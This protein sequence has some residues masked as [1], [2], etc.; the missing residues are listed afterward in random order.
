MSN[1]KAIYVTR[2]ALISAIYF[3]VIGIYI[4]GSCLLNDGLT[5]QVLL[6][7]LLFFIPILYHN[8][9]GILF[10]GAV[11][12]L[13]LGLFTFWGMIVFASSTKAMGWADYIGAGSIMLLFLGSLSFVWQGIRLGTTHYTQQTTT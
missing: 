11:Y 10:I 4:V 13:F 6:F 12:S 5:W 1:R 8:K 3:A 7:S 9:R 2:F